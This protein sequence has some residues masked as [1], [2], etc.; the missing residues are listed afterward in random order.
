MPTLKKG[1]Y[2]KCWNYDNRK[3]D[4]IEIDHYFSL[5]KMDID[6]ENIKNKI[7]K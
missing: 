5:M 4:L 6:G 7:L 2:I 1:S 3:D